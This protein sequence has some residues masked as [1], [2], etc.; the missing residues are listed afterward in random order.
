MDFFE[1]ETKE[2]KK[3]EKEDIYDHRVYNIK[4][5]N[6]EYLL[7]IKISEQNIHFIISLKDIIEYNYKIKMNLSSIVDKLALNQKKYYDL[8]LILKLFDKIYGNQKLFI[9]I[10]NDNSCTL[11][12]KFINALEEETFE[13]KLYKNFMKEEDKYNLL[14]NEI[15]SLKNKNNNINNEKIEQMNNRINELEN[16]I[17]QKNEEIKKIINEKDVIIN[18]MKDD[19]SK[20]NNKIKEQ[21]N[22]INNNHNIINDILNNLENIAE[23]K[24]K[25]KK[26][27]EK[28]KIQIKDESKPIE[29]NNFND[30]LNNNILNFSINEKKEYENKINHEFTMDPNNL[31][32]KLDITTTNTKNGWNDMFEI[33]ISNKDNKEYLVSP[34]VD[35]C[36]LDIFSLI[37]QEKIKSVPGHKNSIRTIRYFMN[38][39]NNNEYLI[40]GDDDKKVIIWEITNNYN[41]NIDIKKI[42]DTKYNKNIYSCLLIFPDNIDD[43][44]IVTSSYNESEDCENSTKVYSLNN[45]K[46][47][48]YINKTNN[49]PIY[50]LLT[51]NNKNNNK[52]YIIQFSYGKI[53]INNLLEDELYSELTYEPESDH[54]SGFIFSKDNKDYLCS[55]ATN[56]FI[57]IWDLYDKKVLDTI[58][59]YG[60]KLSH[61]IQWNSKYFIVAARENKIIKLIDI[62]KKVISEIKSGH[63]EEL[64]SIKKILHPIFGESLLTAS[65]DKKIKLWTTK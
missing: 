37:N 36:Y 6:N 15:K 46:L 43:I 26:N 48:K 29:N 7:I 35:N 49:I 41:I 21:E 28:S 24:V 44:Y 20:L 58:N 8:S 22:T 59:I 40:S 18:S 30:K 50:Y 33:F 60:S 16:K 32:Y 25:N 56:G 27:I 31:K 62:E 47:I 64:I 52:L 65:R 11:I 54:F 4:S 3:N 10:N 9:K 53:L 38:N 63:T 55:S 2:F 5:E 61:M 34:N 51:W 23:K 42:I 13:I 57:N 39:K 1:P 17:E 12:I 19:I 45:N 14:F